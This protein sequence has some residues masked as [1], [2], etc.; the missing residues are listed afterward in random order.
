MYRSVNGYKK[1]ISQKKAGII[2]SYIGQIVH[3]LTGL[4]YTPVML[5]LLGQSEYG[6]YQLV[7]S[8]V[9]YLSLLS[10]GFSASYMRFYSKEQAENND[11][12]V[13][14]LNGM[15]LIVF[16]IMSLACIICGFIMLYNIHYI[17]G[18]GLTEQEYKKAK[19]LLFLMVVNMALTFPNS[20]FNCIITSQERFVFQKSLILIQY[21]ANPILTF[22]LLI[23]GYGS[24]VMVSITTILTF[25]VLLTN[26][27]YCFSRLK[28]RFIF[29]G[30]QFKILKEMMVF[31]FFI[32]INQVIDQINWNVDKI[33]LGRMAGTISVAIYSVGAQINTLYVQM[34][35]SVS[36]VYI[37]QVNRIVAETDDNEELSRIF[38]KVGRIQ[39]IIMTLLMT[40]FIF[41]GKSFIK[42][43]AGDGYELAY[44]VTLLLIIPVT[45]PLIQNIGIEIQRAKDM[46]KARSI[47]Y[48]FI[49]IGNL[50]LSYIL[51]KIIGIIGSAIGT[52]ISLLVGNGV[53]MN[54]YYYKKL[55]INIPMFWRSLS[56]FIP[57][58]LICSIFGV[59]NISFINYTSFWTMVLGAAM[60]TIIYCLS[61]YYTGMNPEEKRAIQNILQRIKIG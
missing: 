21:L 58:I 41:F 31:T 4:I 55:G 17:F 48:L 27:Y 26:I 14:R 56:S 42:L 51:V 6:L 12:G 34:S 19:V 44:F 53:F 36:Q 10:L 38:I 60:Y 15:F 30:L 61:F 5:H 54:W 18:M 20:V 35:T 13:A 25:I 24:I 45:I 28:A 37:P 9:S 40:G 52:A 43:W 2:L 29:R 50:I 47:V 16:G 39:F 7:Y 23:L 11:N 1:S 32:F 49:A 59:L 46:H 8:V 57:S 22:P 3:I 33:L